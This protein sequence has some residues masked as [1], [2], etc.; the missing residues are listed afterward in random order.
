MSTFNSA[1]PV[2]FSIDSIRN[3]SQLP[4]ELLNRLSNS[5]Y[6]VDY[7]WRYLFLNDNSKKAF[8]D[9]AETLIGK[10]AIDVFKGPQFQQVFDNL[11]DAVENKTP[12]SAVVYSPLRGKQ[13]HIKGFPLEDCY[14]FSTSVLPGKDE[15][16]SELR[17]QLNGNKG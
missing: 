12:F 6:V 13:V 1:R 16:L 17:A 3:Y 4:L 11:R 9:I 2:E 10:S 7:E 14:F 5:V 15:L 8:G